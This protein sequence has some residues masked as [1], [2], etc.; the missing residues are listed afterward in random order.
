MGKESKEIVQVKEILDTG[1]YVAELEVT[2][3]DKIKKTFKKEMYT[4]EKNG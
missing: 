2:T 1:G 4:W 3:V